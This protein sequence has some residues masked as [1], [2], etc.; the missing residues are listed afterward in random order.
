[1]YW[2]TIYGT[3]RRALISAVFLLSALACYVRVLFG[4]GSDV[5]PEASVGFLPLFALALIQISWI[6]RDRAATGDED[7]TDA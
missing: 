6:R 1:M 4:N 7:G 3:P 2:R 5:P